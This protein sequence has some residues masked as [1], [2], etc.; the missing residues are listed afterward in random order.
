MKKYALFMIKRAGKWGGPYA[1]SM[2]LSHKNRKFAVNA[3]QS[4]GEWAEPNDVCASFKWYE[5][6][7]PQPEE[8]TAYTYFT[9]K[10]ILEIADI[11]G[12]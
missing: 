12:R 11:L 6:S 5:F 7:E 3:G 4:Y 8:P 1:K 9:L 2:H 10:H